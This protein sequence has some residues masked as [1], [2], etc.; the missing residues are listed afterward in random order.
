[1]NDS[2]NRRVLL[3]NYDSNYSNK[4]LRD[5]NHHHDINNSHINQ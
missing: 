4:D 5:S 2:I 3:S 1:M